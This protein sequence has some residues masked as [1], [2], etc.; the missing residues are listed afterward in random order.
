MT[1]RRPQNLSPRLLES[2]CE[3]FPDDVTQTQNSARRQ[4]K[5]V[6]GATWSMLWFLIVRSV[7]STIWSLIVRIVSCL[8]MDVLISEVILNVIYKLC[9][10]TMPRDGGYT[11]KFERLALWVEVSDLIFYTYRTCCIIQINGKL[12]LEL[13]YLWRYK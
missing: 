12:L 1:R 11:D 13:W 7:N 2:L 8:F 9:C 5:H 6:I 4:L 10:I 3:Y